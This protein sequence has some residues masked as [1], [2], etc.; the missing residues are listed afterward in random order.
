VVWSPK[1]RRRLT[2]FGDDALNAWISIEANPQIAAFCERPVV[3]RTQKPA[4]VVDF[5]VQLPSAEELWFLRRRREPEDDPGSSIAPAFRSWAQ[6]KGLTLRYVEP[7]GLLPAEPLAR[8]WGVLLRY[9]TANRALITEDLLERVQASCTSA[10]PLRALEEHLGAEDPVLVRT[11]ALYL[12]QQGRV[13]SRDF[14][15]IPVGPT[16]RFEAIEAA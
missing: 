1:I 14:G 9:V 3:S 8:N 15:D 13:R 10:I 2:L 16:M 6:D 4:R 5:W 7:A 12:L 11:A